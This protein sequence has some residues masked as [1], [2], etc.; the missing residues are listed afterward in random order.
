MSGLA[1]K[2]DI[3][4]LDAELIGDPVELLRTV[5]AKRYR[6]RRDADDAPERLGF[7]AED[8][9]R[10]IRATSVAPATTDGV[11]DMVSEAIDYSALTAL[12]WAA[13]KRI[14]ERLALLER[15]ND[16]G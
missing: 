3:Q 6:L 11:E 15:D 8:M 13:T 2:K 14:D 7:I 4:D 9:P 5:N 12:L 10:P 16:R 1:T